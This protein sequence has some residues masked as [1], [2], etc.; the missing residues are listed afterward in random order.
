MTAG[1]VECSPRTLRAMSMPVVIEY[2]SGFME[3][4]EDI[5]EKCKKIFQTKRDII[6]MGAEAIQGLEA[7]V[8][9]VMN[10]GEKVLVLDSGP[11]GNWFGVI[12]KEHRGKIL[13]LRAEYNDVISPDDVERKLKDE[14]DIKAL[15]VVHS[16][17]PT[18]TINPVKEICRVGKE[19]GVV[20]IV[21]AVSSIGGINVKPDE[22]DIDICIT[23]SQKCLSAAP[24]LTIM[25][26]SEDA[27]EAMESKKEPIRNS[28]L[29][30]LDWREKWLLMD[31]KG[32]PYTPPISTLYGLSE[33]MNEIFEEGLQKVFRRHSNIAEMTRSGIE[34]MGLQLWPKSRGI[35]S[36]SV[37][38]VAV[39][40]GINDKELRS[41]M[42]EKYQVLIN[43]SLD[44][45]EGKVIRIGHMG[46]N[47]KA[48]N[49]VATLAALECSL[50]DMGYPIEL[51][52]GVGAAQA[53]LRT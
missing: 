24:G 46:Y 8:A 11:Y 19:H 14:R 15:T 30:I 20:T 44:E 1:P 37:T 27:W 6:I 7:S 47:A 42:A 17:T 43:G 31:K 22:W 34:G 28:Y 51:G 18:G 52:T 33:A 3:F 48:L 9:G 26:V 41:L 39:P 29:S 49:I 5:T 38:A 13:K 16:E 32:F 4:F 21:D 50:K 2:Y 53:A 40:T 45:L 12:V 23:A 10:P 35:S 36:N 25:S